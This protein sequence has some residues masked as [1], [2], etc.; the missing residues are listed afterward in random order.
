M[1]DIIEPLAQTPTHR[2]LRWREVILTNA[3]A[4]TDKSLHALAEW[5]PVNAAGERMPGATTRDATLDVVI[6]FN[7]SDEQHM[8]LY[9]LLDAIIKNAHA[10][11]GNP[12]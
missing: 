10:N 8:Q 4:I 2:L 5:A 3:E 7:P 9:A 6:A 11:R 1:A 12:S